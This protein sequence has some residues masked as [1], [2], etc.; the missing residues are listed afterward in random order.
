MPLSATQSAGTSN[1]ATLSLSILSVILLPLKNS[2]ILDLAAKGSLIRGNGDTL[3]FVRNS[4][5][6]SHSG[7]PL[8]DDLVRIYMPLLARHQITHACHPDSSCHLGAT[9]TLK[10]LHRSYRWIGTETCTKWWIR[11]CLKCQTRK[12]SC[13]TICWPIFPKPLLNSPSISASVDYFELLP[14]RP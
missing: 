11:H 5:A 14:L 1:L 3:L 10:M 6:T 2:P 13:Q 12:T 4:T 7:R 8:F 9:R